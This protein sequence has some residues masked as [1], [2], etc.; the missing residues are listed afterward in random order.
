MNDEDG[1]P[2]RGR[3][4]GCGGTER[5]HLFCSPCITKL[6]SCPVCRRL[7]HLCTAPPRRETQDQDVTLQTLRTLVRQNVW[8]DGAGGDSPDVEW[9]DVL[10]DEDPATPPPCPPWRAPTWA[11]PDPGAD[12]TIYVPEYQHYDDA[13]RD[14]LPPIG[15]LPDSWGPVTP[16][17][18]NH[19]RTIVVTLTTCL[20]IAFGWLFGDAEWE[21]GIARGAHGGELGEFFHRGR[22][23]TPEAPEILMAAYLRWGGIPPPHSLRPLAQ[24]TQQPHVPPPQPGT[25]SNA[26]VARM[27]ARGTRLDG[28]SSSSRRTT[29]ITTPLPRSPATTRTRATNVRARTSAA[30]SSTTPSPSTSAL[31]T[32]VATSHQQ[33][34]TD[35]TR[36]TDAQAPSRASTPQSSRQE[37]AAQQQPPQHQT[38]TGIQRHRAIPSPT[39]TGAVGTKPDQSP[40]TAHPHREPTP[41]PVGSPQPLTPPVVSAHGQRPAASQ[42]AA[43]QA[44]P[45]PR[46][47]H[48]TPDRPT[49]GPAYAPPGSPLTQ[50]HTAT[51]TNTTTTRP[52]DTVQPHTHDLTEGLVPQAQATSCAEDLPA[53]THDG[54]APQRHHAP[55]TGPTARPAEPASPGRPATCP[56]PGPDSA[57]F[58]ARAGAPQPAGPG[59]RP[60]PPPVAEGHA[61]GSTQPTND[62]AE[63]PALPTQ[64]QRGEPTVGAE[65]MQGP[66]QRTPTP[67]PMGEPGGGADRPAMQSADPPDIA[68]NGGGEALTADEPDSEPEGP[69]PDTEC[70]D[71]LHLPSQSDRVGAAPLAKLARRA[72]ASTP[73]GALPRDPPETREGSETQDATPDTP[74]R[75]ADRTTSPSGHNRDDDSFDAFMESC[76]NGPHT[77]PAPAALRVHPEPRRHHAEDRP[78]TILR[79]AHLQR[80]YTAL[81]QVT[82][83][84]K[85]HATAKGAADGTKDERGASGDGTRVEAA[86]NTASEP[87][88]PPLGTA[89][90][91]GRGHL[92]YARLEGD[93]NRPGEQAE[94][95]AAQELG[96]WIPRHTAGEQLALAVSIRWLLTSRSRHLAEGT[97]TMADIIFGH[98]RRNTPPATMDRP[99]QWHYVATRLM[100]HMG[101]Y[102]PDEMN[103]LHWQWHKRTALRIRATMHDHDI[104]EIPA[105]A[106]YQ[107]HAPSHRRRRS[108]DVPE[109]PTQGARRNSPERPR[110]PPPGMVSPSGTYRNPL[111]PFAPRRG[112]G[113]P[114]TS[115]MQGGTPEQRQETRK[116]WPIPSPQPHAASCGA[117]SRLP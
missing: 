32:H 84:G 101:A 81:G 19:Y 50:A 99:G 110:G 82:A 65:E 86:T 108:Q 13:P 113:S 61:R 93:A 42:A 95:V 100:A 90:P 53:T 37:R 4:L 88:G 57:R 38:A 80:D 18:H 36:T 105:S 117:A 21:M 69:T 67:T 8:N 12:P 96:L 102:S 103:G 107:G 83:A 51:P 33:R 39:N 16:M 111:R 109:P 59:S 79:Q 23:M 85:G 9:L 6:W 72:D 71:S 116:P 52:S 76:M 48:G 45:E 60:E 75:A 70:E 97:R 94:Q 31:P 11:L 62:E 35:T 92:D 56:G 20:L 43:T 55:L 98:R 26:A 104:W 112:L 17:N 89:P 47:H 77:I 74:Q 2:L 15:N 30:T 68:A 28:S 34:A 63:P 87:T 106:G 54:P 41:S 1:N 25:Y 10:T 44:H 78:L 24:R 49:A 40:G 91:W 73:G 3:D 58:T 22:A 114:H 7:H 5:L 14:S 46:P 115:G 64:P 27:M 66:P 29:T